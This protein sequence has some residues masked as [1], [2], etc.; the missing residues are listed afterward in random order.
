MESII[1]TLEKAIIILKRIQT[2]SYT[3]EIEKIENEMRVLVG[4]DKIINSFPFQDTELPR[5]KELWNEYIQLKQ[6]LRI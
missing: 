1:P 3:T 5:S 4:L 6:V 2:M